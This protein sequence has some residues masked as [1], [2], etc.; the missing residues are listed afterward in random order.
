MGGEARKQIADEQEQPAHRWAQGE[1]FVS[2]R[3]VC[4]KC[5]KRS[6]F[7]DQLAGHDVMCRKCGATLTVPGPVPATVPGPALATEPEPVDATEPA[8]DEST[9]EAADPDSHTGARWNKWSLAAAREHWV[10]RRMELKRERERERE[11]PVD[12]KRRGRKKVAPRNRRPRQVAGARCRECEDGKM[13][14]RT[15]H[16]LG[17]WP[18]MVGYVLLIPAILGLI[19]NLVILATAAFGLA[20]AV[21][22][23]TRIP[24]PT[25]GMVMRVEEISD[26]QIALMTAEQQQ[27]VRAAR[28]A[29]T[30]ATL[31]GMGSRNGTGGFALVAWLMVAMSGLFLSRKKQILR[32]TTCEIVLSAP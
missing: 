18:A 7:P 14:S 6:K 3:V 5:R 12:R 1:L 29:T 25:V 17:R 16:R 30:G 26:E 2:I 27:A 9:R 20:K 28:L 22:D 4:S 23:V 21:S 8:A 31:G 10:G 24:V 32:C 13:R 19:V 15:V 11:R